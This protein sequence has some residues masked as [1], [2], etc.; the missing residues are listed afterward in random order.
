[1]LFN[2]QN[3]FFNKS[4]P[5]VLKYNTG[6]MAILPS[7]D[8]FSFIYSW[9]DFQDEISEFCFFTQ[10]VYSIVNNCISVLNKMTPMTTALFVFLKGLAN[11]RR[12]LSPANSDC[13]TD[14]HIS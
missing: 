10:R 5:S 11:P 9:Y 12:L 3:D 13:D 14:Q 6:P 7:N 8:A 1:M 2:L 4:Q